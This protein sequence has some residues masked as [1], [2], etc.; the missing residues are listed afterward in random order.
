MQPQRIASLLAPFLP[1]GALSELQ[2]G[3]ISNHLDL[4][5]QWN[6]RI[7]LTSVRDPEA[8]VT[9]HFG[10]SFFLAQTLFPV[11]PPLSPAGRD[12]VGDFIAAPVASAIDLGSGAGFPGLP[13]KIWA[14]QLPLTLIES[15][16]KKATF[17]KEV[18]RRNRLMNI[19]VFSGR[20][21][22]YAASVPPDRAR[23]TLVT[24]RA[25]E[26]FQHSLPLAASLLTPGGMLALL[27]GTSQVTT[28]RK[29]L[30]I[31]WET[32]IP[33]PL[34]NARVLVTGRSIR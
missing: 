30:P 28:A 5:L 3:Q 15:Q 16:N 19:N 20:A 34:S 9:R 23:A 32:P 12:R 17:L 21:E 18:I 25:V 24:M 14:P 13:L 10:E 7:N 8:I 27:V 31:S 33:I 4:L 26:R 1:S 11:A 6:A 2:L 22:T 29:I